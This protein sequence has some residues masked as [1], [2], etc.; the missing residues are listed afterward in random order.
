MKIEKELLD[1]DKC[2]IGLVISHIEKLQLVANNIIKF[3]IKKK[4]VGVYICLNRP[5]K[6]VKALLAKEK[7]KTD[8]VFFI[9]CIT[10]SIGKPDK[11]EGVLHICSPSDLRSVSLA[12]SEFVKSVKEKKYILIDTIATLLIYNKENVV[13]DFIKATVEFARKS[14]T[15]LIVTTPYIKNRDIISR[16]TPFFDKVF[17][18]E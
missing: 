10:S 9:D 3:F 16:I 6:A 5:Q 12:I 13:F 2:N 17:N 1:L 8:K 4:Y 7:I 14:K 11:A 15:P 18:I